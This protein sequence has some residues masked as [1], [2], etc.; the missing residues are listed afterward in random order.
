MKYLLPALFIFIHAVCYSQI[1]IS[2]FIEDKNTKERLP[3]VNIYDLNSRAGYGFQFIRILQ[4][5]FKGN[6][7]MLL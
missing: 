1:T 4:H 5:F 6:S 2:G 3:G 7:A